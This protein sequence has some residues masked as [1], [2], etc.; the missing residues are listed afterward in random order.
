MNWRLRDSVYTF[1]ES[2]LDSVV[3]EVT[4]MLLLSQ[5]EAKFAN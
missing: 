1:D 4:S 3:H 2:L 5:R